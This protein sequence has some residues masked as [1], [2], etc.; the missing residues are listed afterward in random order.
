MD[1]WPV[2]RIVMVII[3]SVAA[4]PMLMA[5]AVLTFLLWNMLRGNGGW[6]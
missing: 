6:K 3:L 5:L 1:C 4:V 2:D